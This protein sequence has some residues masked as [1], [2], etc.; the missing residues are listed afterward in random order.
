MDPSSLQIIQKLW[1]T[2]FPKDRFLADDSRIQAVQIFK[3]FFESDEGLQILTENNNA[4]IAKSSRYDLNILRLEKT[5][6]EDFVETLRSKP[7]DV[8]GS[9]GVALSLSISLRY[10]LLENPILIHPHLY[11][12]YPNSSY[13]E[14]RSGAVGQC[15][16][17][18][19][20][21]LKVPA[22]KP[23]V[24]QAMFI[25]G[26]CSAINTVTF[27]DGIMN[28]PV[29]CRADKCRGKY[30]EF[31]RSSVIATDYQ[32]IKLQEI[33]SFENDTTRVPRTFDVEFRG[34]LVDFCISGDV[35]E[36]VGSI[37][38]STCPKPV[39]VFLKHCI[40]PS[41]T[42]SQVLSRQF[43][44]QNLT[45]RLWKLRSINCI[46]LQILLRNRNRPLKQVFEIESGIV[47][48]S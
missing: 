37:E 2:F 4:C 20:Y 44:R 14:L 3:A 16:S 28:P 40:L 31:Q 17:I 21:V 12:L 25:C 1:A 29:S 35:I 10:P 38:M 5:F 39:E 22:C 30:F 47:N 27:E 18:K 13:S 11:N 24:V 9:I 6:G 33:E 36:V 48:L 15:V 7:D 26:A 42:L 41:H 43:K 32:R 8:I 19:G 34:N 46:S 45:Q 23:L